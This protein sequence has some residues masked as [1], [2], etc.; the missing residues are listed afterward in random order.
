MISLFVLASILLLAWLFGVW[1]RDR[2]AA[3]MRDW[4]HVPFVAGVI[5]LLMALGL[6]L[7]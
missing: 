6:L 7:R 5:V 4:L 3:F 2:R 1:E